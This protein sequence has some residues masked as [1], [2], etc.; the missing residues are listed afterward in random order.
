[1]SSVIGRIDYPNNR[2][3]EVKE[4]NI[5]NENVDVIVNAANGL[6]T[7]GGGVAYAIAQA[8]GDELYKESEKYIKE[9]GRIPVTGVVLT[10][11][12]KLSFKGVIHA[13]GPKFGEGNEGEKLFQTVY[14]VLKLANNNAFSSLA[15]PAISA[16]IFRVPHD[17]CAKA[18]FDAV[19]KFYNDFKYSFLKTIKLVM[20]K[21]KILDAVLKEYEYRKNKI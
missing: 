18:Y 5:L 16:G 20:F 19:D 4:N 14:N 15:F 11:A 7:H 3:F 2:V 8:A 21:G 9:N 13:V 10:T 1:V 6:L 12:G 17:I